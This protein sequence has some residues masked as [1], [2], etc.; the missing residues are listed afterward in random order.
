MAVITA[1]AMIIMLFAAGAWL[2]WKRAASAVLRRVR[3]RRK[4]VRKGVRTSSRRSALLP[5]C[6]LLFAAVFLSA[7]RY[8][9]LLQSGLIAFLAAAIP[10]LAF[11][12]A[13]GRAKRLAGTEGLSL[14]SELLRQYRAG[15]RNIYDAM[16]GCLESGADLRASR[17]QLSLLLIR[18]REA[19]SRAPLCMR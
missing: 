1:E 8:C 11:A 2:I 14:V 4:L 10:I 13:Q 12:A 17:K 15:S 7:L 16:E 19:G 6:M 3:L 18:L 5:L 9:S